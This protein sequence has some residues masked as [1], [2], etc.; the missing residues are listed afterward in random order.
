MC[1]F[2]KAGVCKKGEKCK[3]S[4]DLGIE[5]RAAKA[6]LY[7]D[8]RGI[9]K[10]DNNMANWDQAYLEQV[11]AEKNKKSAL[12]PSAIVCKFFLDAV[13]S[14]VYGWFW[15]CPNGENCQYRHCLPPG[16]IL[17][18]DKEKSENLEKMEEKKIEEIIDRERDELKKKPNLTPINLNTFNA[19]KKR[20]QEEREK[21]IADDIKRESKKVGGKA[22]H[23]L[24]GRALFKY[25]PT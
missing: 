15:E 6:D 1:A 8:I 2:F 19:W 24:T 7:T 20:K 21:K 9:S 17:K 4:H 25:D 3:F 11:I 14:R 16:F 23:M 13:E 10:D 5:R 22:F 18:R 12:V